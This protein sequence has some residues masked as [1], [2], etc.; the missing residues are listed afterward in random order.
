MIHQANIF[1]L[2]FGALQGA[3]LS[4]WFFRNHRKELSNVYM[5]VF[6]VIVGLQLTFKVITKVWLMENVLYLYGLSYQFPLLI[7]PILYLYTQSKN[8]NTFHRKDLLHFVPFLIATLHECASL[9]HLPGLHIHPHSYIQGAIQSAILSAYAFAAYKI[10][11]PQVRGF[12]RVVTIV[13]LLIILTLAIMVRYYGQLPDLRL[14]FLSL[15]ILIYWISYR[16]IAASAPFAAPE[17]P[18]VALKVQNQPKYAHSSLK[19]EEGDRIEA[20]L[21]H[22]IGHEKLYLEP[23][24]TIDILAAKLSTSR[25]HLSQVLNERLKKTYADY[26]NEFRLEEARQRLSNQA[27]FRFTIA[28]IALDSGFNSVSSFN[29]LFRKRYGTTPSKYREPF[30]KKMSA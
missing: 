17:K 4:L 11:I 14:L 27:H 25:H 20:Q 21:H 18:V 28:A 29:E 15:T 8:T 23:E 12:I 5:G 30:L 13:E 16:V 10:S 7:G 3:L 1:L 22:L 24:L 19:P 2:L 6:L 26:V 9:L